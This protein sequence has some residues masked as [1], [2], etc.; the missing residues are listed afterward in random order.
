MIPKNDS[1][2]WRMGSVCFLGRWDAGA[3]NYRWTAGARVEISPEVSA[4][5]LME[6]EVAELKDGRLLVVW[7]GSTQGWDGTVAKTPGRKFYSVSTDGGRTLS[8]P[9]EWRY[10]DGSSFYS[11]SSFH[12][13]IRAQRHGQALLARQHQRHAA[14]PAIRRVIRS[15]SQKWTRTGP[16]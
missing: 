2:P 5:G 1:R 4:R 16:R 9:A 11:P 8:P 13:M 6:P 14:L 15:S 7:R 10:D 12:R 3:K